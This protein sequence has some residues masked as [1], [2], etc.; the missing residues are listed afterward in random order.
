MLSTLL[1]NR[2]LAIEEQRSTLRIGV[3]RALGRADVENG[4]A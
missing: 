2:I 3:G 4:V 1:E